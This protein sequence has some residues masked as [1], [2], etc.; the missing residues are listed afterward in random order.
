MCSS[1]LNPDDDFAYLVVHQLGTK[2]AVQS[3]TGGEILGVG[4]SAARTV[5]VS[6][7]PDG[8]DNP[9]SCE[10]AALD[11]SS[12]QLEFDCDGFTDGTSGSPL[13]AST[14]PAGSVGTVIGVIGGYEQGGS[15]ESVSYAAKF[16]SRM[17]A[18]YQTALAAAG[19]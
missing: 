2:V 5:R 1:D 12:T 11:F 14:G 3:L 17:A 16:S 15:T 8:Q 6:G 7:Y 13:L 9:I 10:N 4:Q 19:R 18:L